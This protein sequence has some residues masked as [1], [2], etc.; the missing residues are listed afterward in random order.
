M[1]DLSTDSSMFSEVG[2]SASSPKTTKAP[3]DNGLIFWGSLDDCNALLLRKNAK[4]DTIS[5]NI[6]RR[7]S[8][9]Q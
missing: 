6:K 9:T 8:E 7:F 2:L 3:H 1:T 5:T 4:H